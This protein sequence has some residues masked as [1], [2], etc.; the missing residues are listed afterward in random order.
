VN[1]IATASGGHATGD[2]GDGFENITGSAFDDFLF[3]NDVANELRGRAGD[4]QLFGLGGADTLLGGAGDD[5]LEGGA[6]ADTLNGGSQGGILFVADVL[7]YV[8]SPAAVTVTLG[9][10]GAETIGQGGHAQGDRIANI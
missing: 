6:G 7:S 1:N 8:S 10:N 5:F 3:A 4:D 2:T 9:N